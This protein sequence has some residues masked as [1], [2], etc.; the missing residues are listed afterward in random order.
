MENRSLSTANPIDALATSPDATFD[1]SNTHRSIM[2]IWNK[3][4]ATLCIIEA[5][6]V[7]Y[8]GVRSRSPI[9]KSEDLYQG[10]NHLWLSESAYYAGEYCYRDSNSTNYFA[11]FKVRTAQPL[12]VLE[13]PN[14]FHPADAFFEYEETDRG[15]I[16]DYSAPPRLQWFNEGQADHHVD[17]HFRD[18]LRHH[19]FTTQPTGHVRRATNYKHGAAPGAIIEFYVADGNAIEVIEWIVPPATKP[20]FTEAIGP[21]LRN[22]AS[23]LFL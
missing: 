17:I 4:G 9:T 6:T 3:V 21:D 2:D 18:I 1:F 14:S 23:I 19:Q 22:A 15:F 20:Q 10:R 7:F 5:D 16:V 13:F 11:L 12:A 8:S